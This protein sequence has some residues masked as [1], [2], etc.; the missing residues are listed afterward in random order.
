MTGA[1]QVQQPPVEPRV[2]VEVHKTV[3]V[4]N[5]KGK[6]AYEF[7]NIGGQVSIRRISSATSR[8]VVDIKDLERAVEALK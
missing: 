8:L 6:P 2:R 1:R 4:L 3:R 7:A 5:D